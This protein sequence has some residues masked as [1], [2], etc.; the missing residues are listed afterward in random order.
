MSDTSW[1]F[2]EHRMLTL[3]VA[4]YPSPLTV[5]SMFLYTQWMFNKCLIA[6]VTQKKT[7]FPNAIIYIQNFKTSLW[8]ISNIHAKGEPWFP[9]PCGSWGGTS[10][11]L[12][13]LW[14]SCLMDCYCETLQSS[15]PFY[16]ANLEFMALPRTCIL[17]EEMWAVSW[18]AVNTFV[19]QE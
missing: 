5:V 14:K 11:S 1:S 6:L 2:V 17:S 3:V 7:S 13:V 16:L 8:N 9:W 19:N 18:L 12:L 15:L 10:A 4:V